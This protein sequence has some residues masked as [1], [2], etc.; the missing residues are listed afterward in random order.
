MVQV[1]SIISLIIT[2]VTLALHDGLDITADQN[3]KCYEVENMHSEN[4]KLSML[5]VMI[6]DFFRQERKV[7]SLMHV[8]NFPYLGN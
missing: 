8:K 3:R 6:E 4:S 5:I 2:T 7:S 1:I